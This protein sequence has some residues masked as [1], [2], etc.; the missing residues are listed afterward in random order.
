MSIKRTDFERH[1]K[2]FQFK[3]LFNELGWDD[4]RKAESVAADEQIFALDAVAEKR[5]FLIFVCSPQ[6]DGKIP[7]ASTRKKIDRAITRLYFEHLII[8]V[9]F[10]QRTQVW[11]LSIREPNKPI[12]TRETTYYTHQTP[13]LLFQRLRGLF[14][15]LEEEDKIGL[16]DVKQRVSVSFNTNAEKVTKK[17]Y[18][19]FKKEHGAFLKFIEGV[20]RAVDRDWYASLMLNRLMF[21]YFIQKKGFLDNDAN[22]LRNRLELLQEKQGKNQFYSFYR[23]FLLVLFHEGLGSPEEDETL[24]RKIG[25]VPYLNGGLFDVHDIEKAYK[26][27]HIDDAAF[28]RV[29]DFFDQWNWHL[30]TSMSASGR[31]INPDVIGYIF[32]KYI[33]DRAA[34]GAYYTKEDITEYISKNCIIP[35]LFE[36]T[37]KECANAF[38]EDSSLWKML[39]DNPDRYIYEA[40]KHGVTFPLA[41]PESS[42]QALRRGEPDKSPF[43][44]GFRG[45]SE[46][47]DFEKMTFNEKVG[48]GIPEE[49]AIG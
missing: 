34:M 25:K 21:I 3:E 24:R 42:G 29:F 6:N 22:Y 30:D 9:D 32:E 20:E 49:I 37:K 8:F 41:P 5:D 27:I 17:F 13:E 12:V 38:R 4:V 16:V 23:D 48:Y 45:M 2:Q 15:T 47:P 28:E 1:I 7:D 10:D 14:F 19:S 11:Q 36:Q 33:N 43:E 39:R 40:V 35:Y 44:G 31:D 26:K 18:D 46:L